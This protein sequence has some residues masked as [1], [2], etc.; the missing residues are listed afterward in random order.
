MRF[1]VD[2]YRVLTF[3]ILGCLVISASYVAMRLWMETDVPP[4]VTGAV[5]AAFV[6]IFALII[7]VIGLTATFISAHD[8]LEE[9]TQQADRIAYALEV[10]ERNNRGT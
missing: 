3:I 7:L 1:I 8:R 5:I 4:G 10:M 2:L 9:L 6:A